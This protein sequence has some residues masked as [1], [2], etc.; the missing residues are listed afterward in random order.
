MYHACHMYH[1]WQGPLA[2]LVTY[3][4]TIDQTI[5]SD[6]LLI[7]IYVFLTISHN[8]NASHGRWSLAGAWSHTIRR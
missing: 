7:S 1:A 5:I 3:K 2:M 8:N 4:R 6:Q